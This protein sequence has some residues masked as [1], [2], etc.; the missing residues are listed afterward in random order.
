MVRASAA[1]YGSVL[2]NQSSTFCQIREFHTSPIRERIKEV[3]DNRALYM[4]GINDAALK[5]GLFGVA[6]GKCVVFFRSEELL[7]H[8]SCRC[9]RG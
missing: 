4:T 8:G 6:I 5:Y 3:W 7:R 1:S 2:T 9:S